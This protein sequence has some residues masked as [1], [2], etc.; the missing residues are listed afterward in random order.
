MG[1]FLMPG[2]RRLLLQAKLAMLAVKLGVPLPEI[3]TTL[4]QWLGIQCGFCVAFVEVLRKFNTQNEQT[5]ERL[6]VEILEAKKTNNVQRLNELAKE[7]TNG[8]W[9]PCCAKAHSR[10]S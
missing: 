8:N 4:R 6:L 10:L 9:R 1:G 2:T 5:T 7:F 3:L